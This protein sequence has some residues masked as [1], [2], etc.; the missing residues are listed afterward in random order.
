M[1]S[2]GN[3]VSQSSSTPTPAKPS[4]PKYKSIKAVTSGTRYA[5]G[6]YF[7]VTFDKPIKNAPHPTGDPTFSGA[8]PNAGTQ[9]TAVSP[10]TGGFSAVWKVRLLRPRIG[11]FTLT[12]GDKM[13]FT[14]AHIKD[15]DGNSP[16]D[17]IVITVPAATDQVMLVSAEVSNSAK[18]VVTL[19]FDE[20]IAFQGSPTTANWKVFV[21][22]KEVALRTVTIK[23]NKKLVDITLA[24]NASDIRFG[25]V[26]RVEFKGDDTK[27]ISEDKK[28]TKKLKT[29]TDFKVDNGVKAALKT[30]TKAL[31]M[32]PTTVNADIAT[33]TLRR[34]L[35]NPIDYIHDDDRDMV[36]AYVAH[37]DSATLNFY[38]FTETTDAN[39]RATISTIRGL[40]ASSFANTETYVFTT[41]V[42]GSEQSTSI[43]GN[44][45]IT[46]TINVD[47]AAPTVA[48]SGPIVGLDVDNSTTYN[49]NDTITVKFN[50]PVKITAPT[51][52]VKVGTSNTATDRTFGTGATIAP[53]TD[54]GAGFDDEWV[55]TL[56]GTPTVVR[57]NII[58]IAATHI[59]DR[60]GNKATAKATFTGASINCQQRYSTS[61][62]NKD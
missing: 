47:G 24:D 29:I 28:T 41:E 35:G 62:N 46:V 39:S 3:A 34:L 2:I 15:K 50:E 19:T 27:Y 4:G 49:L 10:D 40:V 38:K 43:T 23:S 45:K 56:K 14:A 18:K 32:T 1:S 20:N 8:T 6:D 60:A 36:N 44:A 61:F 16:A 54:D 51:T 13:T 9:A 30:T 31:Y 53:K 25:Q 33:A 58:W 59:E 21:A 12:A 48:G 11:D 7:Y 57:T 52:N 55:I 17:N 22:G 26:V 37:Y 42:E 5:I